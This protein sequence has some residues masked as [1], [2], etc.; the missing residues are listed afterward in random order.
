MS[1]NRFVNALIAQTMYEE[2]LAKKLGINPHS[3]Y[4]RKRLNQYLENQRK[5]DEHS[6]RMHLQKN[7]PGK[8]IN[9]DEVRREAGEISKRRLAPYV[10]KAKMQQRAKKQ[11]VVSVSEVEEKNTTQKEQ[12]IHQDI[13]KSTD[14]QKEIKFVLFHP[15]S[16]IIG[17][18]N[19]RYGTRKNMS[20]PCLLGFI[21]EDN[22]C[23]EVISGREFDII[24]YEEYNRGS[25]KITDNTQV[26]SN[27][28]HICK[29][30]DSSLENLKFIERYVGA[31]GHVRQREIEKHDSFAN[32]LNCLLSYS[33]IYYS[34]EE[35]F[36]FCKSLF[37]FESPKLY[38]D[39]I[40]Y[41]NS[42]SLA[43]FSYIQSGEKRKDE[44][45]EKDNLVLRLRKKLTPPKHT[46]NK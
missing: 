43:E 20:Y 14:K 7:N 21:S 32:R 16:I 24:S 3:E 2:E 1:N 4:G 33:K 34:G 31:K 15:V 11:Q 19:Y 10:E 44:S 9:Y 17:N 25:V 28:V 29:R 39:A 45:V 6:A 30:I 36:N 37:I 13:Q 35:C 38:L 18:D 22:K 23:V 40:D 46:G 42:K 5:S 8:F 27:P 41:D 12:P 26:V